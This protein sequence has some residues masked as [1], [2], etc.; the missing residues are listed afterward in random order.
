MKR[1]GIITL[2]FNNNYGGYLQAYALYTILKQL[3]YE[4]E[5]I[6]R[7]HNR[8]SAIRYFFRLCK[9]VLLAIRFTD[10]AFI[11]KAYNPETIF[12]HKGK[13]MYPFIEEHIKD[14]TKPIYTSRELY[15]TCK[16][17][18][19]AVIVGSD[20]VWRPDYVPK[21]EDFFLSFIKDP[22]TI[23][24]AYAASF[25]TSSPI[26]TTKQKKNCGKLI[27]QFKA[28][29]VREDSGIIFITKQ[30]WD[31]P[32]PHAVLDPTMLLSKEHYLNLCKSQL[33]PLHR[34]TL[35][36]I[37]DTSDNVQIYTKNICHFTNT[38]PYHI[39]NESMW[40]QESYILPGIEK[41]I[42]SIYNADFVFTDSFHGMVFSIILNKP[43]AIY[44][45]KERGSDRFTSLLE[46]LNLI[47]RIIDSPASIE[48]ICTT[49]IKWEQV[50]LKI[51]KLKHDSIKFLHDSLK[52]S[53]L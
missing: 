7:R 9:A 5:L 30:E 20:Q 16:K 42:S 4:P 1:V 18:Y 23:K 8:C 6:N 34:Y 22:Q 40:K 36:Y 19:Y 26:Y 51:S 17:K 52:T 53:L 43:F 33:S 24:I 31:C 45:N 46:K 35:C 25:G 15:K 29:S 2:P 28:I 13:N 47:D 21:I 14:I 12:K 48:Q 27:K 32:S 10:V 11:K 37:L 50:N 3:G 49:P 39:I 38:Q 44:I 41:W